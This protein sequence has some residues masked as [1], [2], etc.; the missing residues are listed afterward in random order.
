MKV[1]FKNELDTH[2]SIYECS[3]CGKVFN[4]DK[5]SCWYGSDKQM[6]EHP[7]KIPYFCSHNCFMKYP[8]KKQTHKKKKL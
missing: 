3:Q 4:W 1:S 6:E 7:E 8:I 2:R 5:G